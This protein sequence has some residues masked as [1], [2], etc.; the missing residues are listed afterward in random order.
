MSLV[1]PPSP[2]ESYLPTSDRP[3]SPWESGPVL[4]EDIEDY[5][6]G[7]VQLGILKQ[8]TFSSELQVCVLAGLLYL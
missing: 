8:F 1:H 4:D 5:E 6:P 3:K 7:S 2:M